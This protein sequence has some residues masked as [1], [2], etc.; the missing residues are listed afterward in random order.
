MYSPPPMKIKTMKISEI[1]TM[2]HE[3]H[4]NF[5]AYGDPVYEELDEAAQAL[6]ELTCVDLPK[7][8][9]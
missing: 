7:E 5:L 8:G 4:T 1:E 9:E 2:S 3:E 6:L